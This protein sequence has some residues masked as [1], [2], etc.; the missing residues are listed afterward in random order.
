MPYLSNNHVY[1][2]KYNQHIWMSSKLPLP[3]SECDFGLEYIFGVNVSTTHVNNN[4]LISSDLFWGF[5]FWYNTTNNIIICKKTPISLWFIAMRRMIFDYIYSYL[6]IFVKS[7]TSNTLMQCNNTQITDKQRD[8]ILSIR[9][10]L[11]AKSSLLWL[12]YI[13][14]YTMGRNLTNVV[15]VISLFCKTAF[16]ITYGVSH[17]GEIPLF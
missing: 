11:V 1:N 9:S 5:S 4:S 7:F 2:Y 6:S 15:I 16:Q 17:W 14:E 3:C 8:F 13:W 10:S 12:V